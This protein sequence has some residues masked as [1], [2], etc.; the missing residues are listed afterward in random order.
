MGIPAG[1]Q[2]G[3]LLLLLPATPGAAV[4][5]VLEP[6]GRMALTNYLTATVI[7]VAVAPALGLADSGRFGAALGL[8]AAILA[9]QAVLSRLWL[10]R[11]R[12]GPVEWPW[13]CVTWLRPVP[14]TRYA[15]AG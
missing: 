12:F 10:D 5:R 14:L 7:V 2:R 6:L 11:F 3:G 9:A 4:S 1:R 15:H 13:R 8:A